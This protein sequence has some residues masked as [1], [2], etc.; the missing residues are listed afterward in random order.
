MR[1]AQLVSARLAQARLSDLAEALGRD[2]ASVCRIR[3]GETRITFAEAMRLI[4]ALGHKVVPADAVCV[5][6]ERYAA[7]AELAAAAMADAQ[8]RQRL[9]WEGEHEA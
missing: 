7:I 6:R 1:W 8:I 2:E 9:I 4:A 3:S 5:S